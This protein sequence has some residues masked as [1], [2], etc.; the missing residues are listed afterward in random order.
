[1]EALV[2]V[3]DFMSETSHS[4]SRP[5]R[6]WEEEMLV[7]EVVLQYCGSIIYRIY[8]IYTILPWKYK[9]KLQKCH[10]SLQGQS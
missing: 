3:V 10:L 1:M 8:C 5:Y 2:K 7:G 4:R 6:W 9:H